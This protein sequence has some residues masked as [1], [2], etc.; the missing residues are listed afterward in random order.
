MP[1]GSEGNHGN[2]RARRKCAP[3]QFRTECL[4]MKCRTL[5]FR[6]LSAHLTQLNYQN[7]CSHHL[8]T[9]TS[10][11]SFPLAILQWRYYQPF[12]KH[13]VFPC[14]HYMSCANC[15]KNTVGTKPTSAD[16]DMWIYHILIAV[17]LLHV[18]VTCCGHLQEGVFFQGYITKTTKPM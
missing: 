4:T 3:T 14:A 18:S 6:Y 12:A 11:A 2:I 7:Y 5:P 15:H 9:S 16:E 8:P 17:N 10:S 1:V 13:L